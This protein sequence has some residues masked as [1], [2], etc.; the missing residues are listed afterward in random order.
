MKANSKRRRMLAKKLKV[1]KDYL[2]SKSKLRSKFG[3]ADQKYVF[4]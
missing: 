4:E 2:K 3:V 1:E